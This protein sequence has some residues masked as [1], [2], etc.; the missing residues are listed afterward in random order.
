M[1]GLPPRE[2]AAARRSA[3]SPRDG[4]RPPARG[5]PG[6]APVAGELD[7]RQTAQHVGDPT[8]LQIRQIAQGPRISGRSKAGSSAL[9]TRIWKARPSRVSRRLRTRV[10]SPL[11]VAGGG[12]FRR[13]VNPLG[14]NLAERGGFE[15]P[16]PLQAC[17]ISSAVHSTTLPPLRAAR[18]RCGRGG[19]VPCTGG[20]HKPAGPRPGGDLRP[21]PSE[22]TSALPR[23]LGAV[24]CRS[25]ETSPRPC[26][27]AEAPKA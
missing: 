27:E 5:R 26:G 2:G 21:G 15:P 9:G 18:E 3:G 24:A 25:P 1:H 6:G 4:G 23:A 7:L 17:R 10:R 22:G 19:L 20:G 13:A 8:R 11:H 12:A 14:R 16:M